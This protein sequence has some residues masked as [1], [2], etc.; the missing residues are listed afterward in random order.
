MAAILPW[1]QCVKLTVPLL[2]CNF[3][4]TGTIYHCPIT[5]EINMRNPGYPAKRALSGVGPFWQDTLGIWV[6]E[7]YHMNP[8][9]ADHTTTINKSQ[10]NCIYSMGYFL[11]GVI[12]KE[13]NMCKI[14]C[15]A[16]NLSI[17][18]PFRTKLFGGTLQWACLPVPLSIHPSV[19]P[20]DTWESPF[21]EDKLN[22]LDQ[23]SWQ[24]TKPI[25]TKLFG[26]T[27]VT[28][29]NLSVHPYMEISISRWFPDLFWSYW[30]EIW[31]TE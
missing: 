16:L 9:N 23:I 25:P 15:S 17:I 12:L 20:S 4:S 19:C 24:I 29:M 27:Q 2:Q 14:P 26:S 6:A 8:V 3:A 22:C 13:L 31:Y 1:P 28:A 21:S 18:I 7:I 10:Q 30:N 5:T 11:H